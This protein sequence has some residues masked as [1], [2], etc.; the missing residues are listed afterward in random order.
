VP[1]SLKRCV[2][3]THVPLVSPLVLSVA[4]A[5]SCARLLRSAQ[6]CGDC[7]LTVKLAVVNCK[8]HVFSNV[9]CMAELLYSASNINQSCTL[10]HTDMCVCVQCV[11]QLQV[12]SLHTH[13]LALTTLRLA[14]ARWLA[15]SVVH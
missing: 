15:F 11:H 7:I 10:S 3:Q 4:D 5:S 2:A 9:V 12:A 6:W 8:R 13:L 14:L 1:L